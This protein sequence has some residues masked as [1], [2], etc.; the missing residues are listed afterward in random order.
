MKKIIGLAVLIF[1]AAIAWNLFSNPDASTKALLQSIAESEELKTWIAEHPADELAS[2]A[3]NTLVK[4]FPFL[5]DV[6]NLDNWRQ[7]L[8][9]TGL[10]LLRDYMADATPET[11][12]NAG[13]LGGVIKILAPDLTDEVDAILGQ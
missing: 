8:K 10:E 13:T 6:L 4:T 2:D 9:T 5:E 12:E 11:R 1:L 7:A 3:K